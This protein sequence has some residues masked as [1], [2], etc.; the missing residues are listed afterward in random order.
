MRLPNYPSIIAQRL[1]L[2]LLLVCLF[3]FITKFVIL[4]VWV[5]VCIYVCVIHVRLVLQE[6]RRVSWTPWYWN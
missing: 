5:F 6:A 2:S 4:C 1:C 3:Y